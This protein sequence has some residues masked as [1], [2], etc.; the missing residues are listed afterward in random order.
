MYRFQGFELDILGGHYS[1]KFTCFLFFSSLHYL[2]SF[3]SLYIFPLSLPSLSSFLFEFPSLSHFLLLKMTWQKRL[4]G[5]KWFLLCS[6]ITVMTDLCQSPPNP[7]HFFTIFHIISVAQVSVQS[8][9]GKQSPWH[10]M[11]LLI[12]LHTVLWNYYSLGNY[13]HFTPCCSAG[14]GNAWLS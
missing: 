2:I 5:T 3:S 11:K 7:D 9:R 1:V 10:W 13:L 12:T 14:I 6:S 8:N 4:K